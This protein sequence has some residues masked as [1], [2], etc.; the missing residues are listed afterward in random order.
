MC[1]AYRNEAGAERVGGRS[2]DDWDERC[3]M[4][5]REDDWV[6]I[7]QN[8]IDPALDELGCKLGG[9][10]TASVRPSILDR[11]VAPFEP[12]EFVE[13]LKKS[14][15]PKTIGLSRTSSQETYGRQLPLLPV[16]RQRPRRR[17]AQGEYEFSP[18]EVH[19]HASLP[20]EVVCMQ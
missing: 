14:R 11:E 19:C 7:G 12:A 6:C 8:D 13:P 18:P 10:I 4:L 3:R 16:R 17:A 15:E 5:Y 9:A 2:E 20:P 1:S